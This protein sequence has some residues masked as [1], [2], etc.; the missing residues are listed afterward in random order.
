MFTIGSSSGVLALSSAPDYDILSVPYY[1]LVVTASDNDCL[2]GFCKTTV[3]VG[4]TVNAKNDNPPGSISFFLYF[5][6]FL[7]VFELSPPLGTLRAK[8]LSFD[9]FRDFFYYNRFINSRPHL[10]SRLL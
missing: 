10:L 7:S 5:L 6:Y 8:F 3:T 4:V 2:A 1:M 9:D